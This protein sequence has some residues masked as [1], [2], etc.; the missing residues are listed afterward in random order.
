MQNC[1][2]SFFPFFGQ[3]CQKNSLWKVIKILMFKFKIKRIL[4]NSNFNF[5]AM[6]LTITDLFVDVSSGGGRVLFG[7]IGEFGYLERI[8]IIFLLFFTIFIFKGRI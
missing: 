2:E 3:R 5:K 1:E 8:L 4:T 6:V 7:F